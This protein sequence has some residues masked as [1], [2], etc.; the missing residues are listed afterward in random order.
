MCYSLYIISDWHAVIAIML[1][2][3]FFIIIA[4]TSTGVKLHEEGFE[5]QLA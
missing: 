5:K 1:V 3:N 4:I 2:A